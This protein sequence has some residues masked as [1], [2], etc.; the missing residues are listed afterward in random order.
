MNPFDALSD[1][2]LG[3]L[4]QCAWA[5]WMKLLFTMSFSAVVSFLFVCGTVLLS[6]RSVVIAVGTG[7]ISAAVA[8]AELFRRSPLTKKLMVVLPAEEAKAEIDSNM[9]VIAKS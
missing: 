5:A 3:R 4:K 2:V 9:Q 8:M 6:T 1:F 7:M